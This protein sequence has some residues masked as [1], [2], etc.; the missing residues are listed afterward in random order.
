MN[1]F[2]NRPFRIR[3]RAK[4][5]SC[6]GK[7]VTLIELGDELGG[8]D[9]GTRHQLGEEAHIEPE[10]QDVFDRIDLPPVYI[11]RIGDGLEGI[12]GDPHREQDGH[13]LQN[14]CPWPGWS[15]EPGGSPL[16]GPD[17]KGHVHRIHEKIGVLEIGEQETGLPP[18]S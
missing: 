12:K 4:P 1:I 16:P 14:G 18:H 17:E 5:N 10:I 7:A 2:L 3:K 8:P 11:D 6:H 15:I 13:S 9:D